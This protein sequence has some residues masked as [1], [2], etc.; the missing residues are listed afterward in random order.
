MVQ[1]YSN[2]SGSAAPIVHADDDVYKA[3]NGAQRRV[4]RMLAR[5]TYNQFGYDQ[6]LQASFKQ[7]GTSGDWELPVRS[8][9]T[10]APSELPSDA[11]LFL[12]SEQILTQFPSL[13]QINHYG[14]DDF[15]Y[16]DADGDGIIDRLPPN[17][18]ST[19]TWLLK[20]TFESHCFQI[21]PN[22]LNMTAPPR[23]KLGWTIT[24]NDQ[25][26][27]WTMTPRGHASVAVVA[28]FLLCLIP[29]L[30]AIITSVSFS[31]FWLVLFRKTCLTGTAA[32]KLLRSHRKTI[33]C[34][35][36]QQVWSSR[37]QDS[38]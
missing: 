7:V 30:T 12:C 37:E 2:I 10:F 8:H 36:D 1:Y 14:F 26:G 34:H 20:R 28:W 38:R 22:Y 24:I 9:L 21:G 11:L 35:Q 13:V 5:G 23:H 3:S 4:P 15:F 19:S 33:L 25:S 27:K 31:K 32:D 18:L 16:G 29:P 6:G 17:S